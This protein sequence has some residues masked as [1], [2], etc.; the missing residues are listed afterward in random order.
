MRFGAY[1]LHL[2]MH[3]PDA[4]APVEFVQETCSALLLLT[5]SIYRRCSRIVSNLLGT[6]QPRLLCIHLGKSL[7]RAKLVGS[8]CPA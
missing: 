3:L 4:N 8:P 6:A 2:P 1:S 5:F 7:S